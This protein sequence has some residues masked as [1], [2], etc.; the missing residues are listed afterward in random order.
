MQEGWLSWGSD[1]KI[2][3]AYN[4]RGGRV[5]L[6][7]HQNYKGIGLHTT[8]LLISNTSLILFQ[9]NRNPFAK[10]CLHL[11]SIN[12][13][14]KLAKH[15]ESQDWLSHALS[16]Y[17]IFTVCL[18]RIHLLWFALNEKFTG[19]QMKNMEKDFNAFVKVMFR[20]ANIKRIC[21]RHV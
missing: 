21:V 5:T 19:G 8:V 13:N 10:L 16:N 3:I 4:L 2:K 1:V 6:K 7:D 20:L 17:L 14:A 15:G 9:L 18:Y 11:G 12:K